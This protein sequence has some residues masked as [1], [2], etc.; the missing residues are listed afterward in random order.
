[1]PEPHATEHT[2]VDKQ[3]IR[4]NDKWDVPWKEGIS[5]A[6]V[7]KACQFTHHQVVVSVQG[8]LVP[9]DE[10]DTQAVSDGD[11]VKVV[12]IIGGG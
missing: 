10:Y 7:L 5:I 4:V 11:E 8:R 3:M 9:P 6:D 1:M 12:H 2:Q